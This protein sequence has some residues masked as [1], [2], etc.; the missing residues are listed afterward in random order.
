MKQNV[1]E[2]GL[3]IV[4]GIAVGVV[5]RGLVCGSNH[6]PGLGWV[7][8]VAMVGLAWYVVYIDFKDAS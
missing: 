8:D 2:R 6:I 1:K 5:I 7:L 3:M 4:L